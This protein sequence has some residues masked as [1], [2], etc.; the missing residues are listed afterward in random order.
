[1]SLSKF[2]KIF[3]FVE[4]KLFNKIAILVAILLVV[5]V[6]ISWRTLSPAQRLPEVV[7]INSTGLTDFSVDGY[8]RVIDG[9]LVGDSEATNL[10]PIGVMIENAADSRPPA[11]LS[12]AKI[13]YEALAEAG[14]TRFLAIF[15]LEDDLKKIGP[16]RS[17]RA[18]YLDWISE[19]GGLYVHVG[20]SPEALSLIKK[21]NFGSK[22]VDE[23]SNG[24][25]FWRDRFRAAPHN[26]YVSSKLLENYLND[27]KIENVGKYA[28]WKF[29]TD[30][31]PATS[32]N[33][34]ESTNKI[35]I[36][37]NSDLYQVVWQYNPEEGIYYRFHDKE[38][39]LDSDGNQLTAK[40]IVVQY[41]ATKVVDNYGRRSMETIGSGRA[42]FFLNGKKIDGGWSKESRTGRTKFFNY[43][44]EEIVFNPGVLWVNVVPKEM[45]VVP[46]YAE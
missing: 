5:A 2:K 3:N 19:Y 37:Y 24:G 10:L 45:A 33:S 13:V 14:I 23:F 18:Y 28:G 26:V 38:K 8:F 29:A 11:G 40:N 21:Y 32:D 35:A 39:H 42:M 17:A 22:N 9:V 41:V 15:T 20:G 7:N 36:P 16:V 43:K 30:V 4:I 27:Y 34:V 31:S 44:N 46:G 25:Y 1:M 12:Q 6:V